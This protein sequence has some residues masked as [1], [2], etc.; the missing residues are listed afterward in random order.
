MGW[1]SQIPTPFRVMVALYT[2][3]TLFLLVFYW[4]VAKLVLWG[5]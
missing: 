1:L 5:G 4:M 2:V 3:G